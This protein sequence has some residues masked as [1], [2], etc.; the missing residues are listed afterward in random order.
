MRPIVLDDP[1]GELG[2]VC[3]PADPASI[4][5]AIRGIVELPPEEQ[6]H[7][8]AKCLE[9]AHTRWNWERESAKLVELYGEL[10]RVD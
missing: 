2:A 10:D 5:A 9:A 7:L 6:T 1:S 4:A 8:R 3:D